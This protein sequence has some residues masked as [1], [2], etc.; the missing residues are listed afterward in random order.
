[1]TP[2]LR[3]S[4][5]HLGIVPAEPPV[6]RCAAGVVTRATK[7][8]TPRLPAAEH[9]ESCLNCGADIGEPCTDACREEQEPTDCRT[10][11]DRGFACG[12]CRRRWRDER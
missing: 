10:C 1:M 4:V 7:A 12:K 6:G 11:G 5:D 3:P 9:R 2:C 8:I